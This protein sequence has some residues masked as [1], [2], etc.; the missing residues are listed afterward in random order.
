MLEYFAGIYTRDDGSSSLH[1][2]VIV[3]HKEFL[4]S[5]LPKTGQ[6]DYVSGRVVIARGTINLNGVSI[7]GASWLPHI[8]VRLGAQRYLVLSEELT[9][10]CADVETLKQTGAA[11]TTA[12]SYYYLMTM[13]LGNEISGDPILPSGEKACP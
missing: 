5:I 11:D 7:H 3:C 4:E 1:Q 8:P 9:R 2:L 12:L 13:D 6:W 10:F